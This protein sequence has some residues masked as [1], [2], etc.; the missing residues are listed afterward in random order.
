MCIVYIHEVCTK[1]IIHNCV[2]FGYKIHVF[3]IFCVFYVQNTCILCIL[4][5]F[6]EK[7]Y[8]NKLY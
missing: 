8:L 4:C 3:Y 1:Y 2:Y 7:I 6:D 5:I